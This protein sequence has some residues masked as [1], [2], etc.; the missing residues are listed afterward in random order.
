MDFPLHLIPLLPLCAAALNLLFG[1]R[2]LSRD[3]SALLA[4]GAAGA[5]LLLGAT[6]FFRMVAAGGEAS[7][8]IHEFWYTWIAAGTFRASLAFLFDPLSGVMTLIGT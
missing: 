7:A 2:F 4:T 5:S 6:A 1:R 3:A 8:S